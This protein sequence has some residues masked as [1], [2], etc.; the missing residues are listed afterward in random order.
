MQ[1]LLLPTVPFAMET[2]YIKGATNL[3]ADCLSRAP[4][5]GCDTIK[6]PILQ[7]NQITA[8]SRCTQEKVDK[9]RQ[10][11][12]K[13][14]TLAL[15][16]HTV[17]HG[18]PQ[19]IQD[20][21]PELRPYWTFRDE[22]TLEDGLLIKGER[23]IIPSRDQA[24]I[25]EQLHY[26]HLGLQKCLHRARATVYWPNL[27]DQLKDLVTNCHICLKYSAAN[28]KDSKQI[29][30][31]LGQ[32]I[33]TI[34]WVKLAT[35]IF[36]FDGHNYLLIVDYM[37]RFP[38]VQHLTKMTSRVVAE[39]MKTIFSELGPPD[40]LVSDNGPCYAG[41][42]FKAEMKKCGI[43]HIT[44][45]PHHHQSNGLAEAYVKI[46]KNLMAK[47]K[48]TGDDYKKSLTIYR[49]TPL[50]DKL[51][52]PFELLHRRKPSLDIPH[53]ER[54]TVPVEHLRV[55]DKNPQAAQDK[56][57]PVGSHV[58]FIT[59]PNKKWFPATIVEHLGHRSY[60]IKAADGTVYRRT[61]LHLK[62]YKPQPQRI[63][64]APVRMDL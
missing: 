56:I 18:W 43:T 52:S 23:I 41:D 4:A 64:R 12:A 36:T 48:E 17:Q 32:E 11:T 26:G 34:P 44:A 37:S 25:L 57:L 29:G 20:L 45:S 51:P 13:D 8:H 55:Q 50:S 38:V 59:P 60:K 9:L 28:R 27:N 58:M 39:H 62:P 21:P 19:S 22:I 2:E 49:T 10:S 47:A 30:P 61:R 3:I 40:T 1:R 5:S 24:E 42:Y 46:V 31:Q 6:L 53:V 14:D 63:K 16:K 7:V 35:D 54:S 33:P 15:L